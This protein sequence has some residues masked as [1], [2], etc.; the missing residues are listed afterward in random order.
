M[1]NMLQN[2]AQIMNVFD[3]VPSQVLTAT[4]NGTGVSI[5]PSATNWLSARLHVAAVTALTTLDVKLQAS[6][7][8]GGTYTDIPGAVFPTVTAANTNKMIDFQ[9]PAIVLPTDPPFLFVRAVST[10]VGTSVNVHC[11]VFGTIKTSGTVA[12]VQ[13]PLPIN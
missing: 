13:Q 5:V 4:G 7:A 10:L 12:Y 6:S 8:I 11:E 3:L 2:Y 9:M 1:A